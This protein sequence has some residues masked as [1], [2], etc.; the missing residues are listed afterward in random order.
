M[1]DI[2]YQIDGIKL[3]NCTPHAIVFRNKAGDNI[4]ALASGYTLK[5]NAVENVLSTYENGLTFVQTTF[6]PSE[7]GI[8]E[9]NELELLYPY[10]DVFVGSIISAQTYPGQVVSLV[11]TDDTIRSDIKDKRYRADKF[12]VF[13]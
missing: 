4:I 6:V 3:I 12:T 10:V 1:Q 13:I 7:E 2:V 9:L 8:K 5:A 11:P